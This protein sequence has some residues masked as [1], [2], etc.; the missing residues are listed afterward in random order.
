MNPVG[1]NLYNSAD[2]PGAIFYEFIELYHNIVLVWR[3]CDN[4]TLYIKP[5]TFSAMLFW[6][7]LTRHKQRFVSGKTMLLVEYDSNF[8]IGQYLIDI[9]IDTF[10]WLKK[11]CK[12]CN[13][14]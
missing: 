9:L 12:I 1:N 6:R 2:I 5:S 11:V 14:V 4:S 8:K 13:M 7:M 10:I 3:F